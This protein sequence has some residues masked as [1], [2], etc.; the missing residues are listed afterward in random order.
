MST[1]E[2]VG[3]LVCEHDDEAKIV[4]SHLPRHIELTRSEAGCIH[5]DVTQTDDPLVW[6]VCERFVSQAAFEVH[7]VRV[8]ES[9]WG[10]ATAGIKREYVITQ[11]ER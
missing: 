1:V 5:F 8:R 9:E 3:R 4:R 6:T 10:R 11:H 7:Q 2:L